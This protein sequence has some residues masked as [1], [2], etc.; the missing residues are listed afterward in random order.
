MVQFARRIATYATHIRMRQA[1]M[2]DKINRNQLN[3]KLHT[4]NGCLNNET[5][6]LILSVELPV[7]AYTNQFIL[8]LCAIRFPLIYIQCF[9]GWN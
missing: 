9:A 7:M 2:Y 4:M 8:C 6:W 5:N 3:L 1:H